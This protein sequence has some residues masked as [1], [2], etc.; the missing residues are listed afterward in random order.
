MQRGDDRQDQIRVSDLRR[1]LGVRQTELLR[2]EPDPLAGRCVEEAGSQEDH[3]LL[4]SDE[5]EAIEGGVVLV[6]VGCQSLLSF[7]KDLLRELRIVSDLAQVD[8]EDRLLGPLQRGDAQHVGEG[9]HQAA[10][11]KGHGL[12]VGDE[13]GRDGERPG[14]E[15]RN[16]LRIGV[17]VVIHESK[18]ILLVHLDPDIFC[19][20][21]DQTLL[22]ALLLVQTPAVEQH[23]LVGREQGVHL[24]EDRQLAVFFCLDARQDFIHLHIQTVEGLHMRLAGVHHS[25][26]PHP[27]PLP[28]PSPALSILH[29]LALLAGE[30]IEE[31]AVKVSG[32]DVSFHQST[33]PAI[34]AIQFPI[35]NSL[36]SC[37]LA[38]RHEH[39]FFLIQSLESR[40]QLEDF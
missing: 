32:I 17:P 26:L 4:V 28:R 2:E 18:G 38:Q 22:L 36:E 9:R 39:F 25:A 23:L 30:G 1:F 35:S 40:S 33:E 34:L 19:G 37:L 12:G 10:E 6:E 16:I 14:R 5:G 24:G 27:R 3:D 8:R 7:E 13:E 29:R 15:L 21:G 11:L 31:R 20:Q